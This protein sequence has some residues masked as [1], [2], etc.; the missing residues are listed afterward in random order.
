MTNSLH[1]NTKIQPVT[2]PLY[3]TII[4]N[5]PQEYKIALIKN[6]LHRDYHISSSKIIFYKELTN[7]KLSLVNNN[8]PNKLINQQIKQYHH[9]I[10]KNSNNNNNDNT[11]RINLCYNN[12]MHK[13]YKL[14]KQV[15]TNIIHRHIKPTDHQKWMKR[16]VYYAKFKTSNLIIK[17]NT[18]SPKLS[19]S[20]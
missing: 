15:I 8:F 7:V 18:N 17:N 20:V 10:Y 19:C 14:D 2:T 5:A 12:Q 13:N 3:L 4:V 6:L 1:P 11:N 9:N 16:I